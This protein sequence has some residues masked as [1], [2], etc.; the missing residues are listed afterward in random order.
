MSYCG[1]ARKIT[2]RDLE[3]SAPTPTGRNTPQSNQGYEII[4]LTDDDHITTSFC[5]RSGGPT[6]PLPV[7]LKN[8]LVIPQGGVVNQH[9]LFPV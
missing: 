6:P 3:S 9:L 7:W 4:D 8:L 2:R 5:Q 1:G